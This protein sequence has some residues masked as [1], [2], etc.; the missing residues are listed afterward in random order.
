MSWSHYRLLM[1]VGNDEER[2]FYADEAVKA[3]WSV[4]QLERQINT[5]FHKRLLASRD[6]QSVSEDISD[7]SGPRAD[8]DIC[9]LLHAHADE[10]GG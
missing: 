10:A 1:R 6:K 4:R 3:G 5:I 7:P 2:T 8:A 9:E